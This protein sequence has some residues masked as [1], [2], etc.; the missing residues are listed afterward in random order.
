VPAGRR[1]RESDL[2]DIDYENMTSIEVT[3]PD[4][5]NFMAMSFILS[6]I[7]TNFLRN[8]IYRIV[9]VEDLLLKMFEIL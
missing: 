8:P 3:V 1:N 2:S 4:D 9:R 6:R 7:T 5:G